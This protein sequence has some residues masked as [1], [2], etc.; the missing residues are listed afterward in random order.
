MSEE[1]KR[2]YQKDID[3]FEEEKFAAKHSF[4]TKLLGWMLVAGIALQAAGSF[5]H[6]SYN[7]GGLVFL[8][9]GFSILKGSQSALRFAAFF[10]VPGAILGSLRILWH[11][12]AREPLEINGEWRSYGDLEFWTLDVSPCMYFA[13]ESIVAACALRLRKIPFWTKPVRLWASVVGM[14]LL[15]QFGFFVRDLIRQREVRR[16]FPKELATAKAHI[17]TYGGS[18]FATPSLISSVATFGE[19]PNI[20]EVMW[21]TS[22]SSHSMIYR[23]NPNE[24]SALGK[25][26]ELQECLQLPSGEWGRIEM[27]LIQPES[28]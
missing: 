24:G 13:A 10:A 23:K 19:F 21:S 28:H 14:L 25:H 2:N 4:P 27:K 26:L 7:F 15:I 16:S 6:G 8:L 11:V 17:L 22:P 3:R 1:Q 18:V 12:A 5:S 20:L 9:A